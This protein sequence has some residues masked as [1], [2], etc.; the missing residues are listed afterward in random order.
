MNITNNH[1]TPRTNEVDEKC[2]KF[3]GEDYWPGKMREHARQLERELAAMTEKS[4]VL[5][6]C[7]MPKQPNA[8]GQAR[9]EKE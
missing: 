4:G 9:R 3:D 5:P 6:D 2:R 1:D 8:Q 7:K